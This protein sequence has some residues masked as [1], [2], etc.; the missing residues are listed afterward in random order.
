MRLINI[1]LIRELI[2]KKSYYKDDIRTFDFHTVDAGTVKLMNKNI[3]PRK[4]TGYDNIPGKLIKIAHHSLS[5]PLCN[6]IK[7][8][9]KAAKHFNVA[10][11]ISRHISSKS[12]SII[13]NSFIASNFNYCHLVWH[14]CG[15]TNSNKL[16]K[17]RERSLRIVNKD[18]ESPIQSLIYKSGQENVLSN[19]LKYFISEVFKSVN[20]LNAGCL[21]DKFVLYEVPYDMRT[22]RLEQPIRR[23]AT[24]G[25]RSFSYLGAKLWNDFVS[26]FNYINSKDISQLKTFLEC[27]KGP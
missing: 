26:D 7:V 20:K 2:R 14:F 8:I 15:A 4:A 1:S 17:L 3:Y 6:L 10:S 25:L 9:S 18:F 24:Y 27:W 13:Y 19:R 21:H 11:R 16:E 23:S 5:I 12:K 22:P